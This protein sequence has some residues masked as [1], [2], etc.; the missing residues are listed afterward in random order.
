MLENRRMT[1][2]GAR[3]NNKIT[4][5]NHNNTSTSRFSKYYFV[6]RSIGVVMLISSI[7]ELTW[8]TILHQTISAEGIG[9]WWGALLL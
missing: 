4:T 8:G 1:T 9:S 3:L 7:L 6:F 5:S 2:A